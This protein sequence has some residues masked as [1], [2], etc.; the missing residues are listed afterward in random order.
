MKI[1]IL[2]YLN[3]FLQV[4]DVLNSQIQ[5]IRCACL[6]QRGKHQVIKVHMEKLQ[7]TMWFSSERVSLPCLIL[8]KGL[9][10]SWFLH[11]F[12]FF[13]PVI[14]TSRWHKKKIS[15]RQMKRISRTVWDFYPFSNASWVSGKTSL[16]TNFAWNSSL[17]LI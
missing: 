6:L 15:T 3:L 16:G 12:L 10:I 5:H 7:S 4:F 8:G 1:N 9:A 14:C 13:F 11:W 17:S 2:Q